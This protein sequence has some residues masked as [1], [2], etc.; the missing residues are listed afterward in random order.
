MK[1]RDFVHLSAC[2]IA[3]SVVCYANR[4]RVSRSGE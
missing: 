3:C 4:Q 1:L 2:M